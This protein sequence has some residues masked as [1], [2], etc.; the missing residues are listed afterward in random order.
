M[1]V[2]PL[3]QKE[4]RILNIIQLYKQGRTIREIGDI[5]DLSYRTVQYHLKRRGVETRPR[6][7]KGVKCDKD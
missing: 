6:G 2:G 5:F 7:R 3:L 4:A 1:K